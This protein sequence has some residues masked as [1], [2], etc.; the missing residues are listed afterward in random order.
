MI[1][2][3]KSKKKTKK[4]LFINIINKTFKDSYPNNYLNKIVRYA[5]NDLFINNKKIQKNRNIFI[6]GFGK[7]TP[8]VAKEL[9]KIIGYKNIEKG[10]LI[11]PNYKKVSFNKKI[12]SLEGT[13]PTP[14]MVSNKSTNTLLKFVNNLS[15]NDIIISIV[16]GGGSSCLSS[17]IS[18]ITIKDDINLTKLLILNSIRIDHI[19]S[20]RGFFSNIKN[21]KLAR[22]IYPAKIFNLI[23]S[24]DPRNIINSIG[25][26]AT[27]H[28]NITKKTVLKILNK[29]KLINKIP[30]NMR[31]NLQ[32]NINQKRLKFYNNVNNTIIFQN[33]D[34]LINFK[35][36]S[37]NKKIKVII[38]KNVLRGD[39]EYAK[40]NFLKRL[41]LYKNFRKSLILF[42]SETE[43]EV[44][45]KKS[46]GGRV[47]HFGALCAKE[48]PKIFE[49]YVFFGLATD[50]HDYTRKISG[51]IYDE[52]DTSKILKKKFFYE[53][54]IKKFDSFTLF[55]KFKLHIKLKKPTKNNVFDVIGLYID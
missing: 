15:Q 32:L 26:G 3:E 8:Y 22:I 45:N 33:K 49:K 13:H 23:V 16:S 29:K 18:G 41:I 50:G 53:N 30:L 40:K 31:K 5:G 47:Q 11:S 35:K 9:I 51:I 21:G 36:N 7:V 54:S 42:G 25:S 10:L 1:Y 14:S 6:I 17:P 38:E 55:K 24:D 37:E 4:N 44:K 2:I 46:K 52:I 34:F 28:S 48:L 12:L 27:V 39:V 43:V 19:N 20:V